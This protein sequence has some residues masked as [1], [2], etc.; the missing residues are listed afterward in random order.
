M[1]IERSLPTIHYSFTNLISIYSPKEDL[2]PNPWLC[3]GQIGSRDTVLVFKTS[4]LTVQN[5]DPEA[6]SSVTNID[7][8]SS[9]SKPSTILA[10]INKNINFQPSCRSNVEHSDDV[11]I[12]KNNEIISKKRSLIIDSMSSS[13]SDQ[14]IS[15]VNGD[16]TDIEDAILKLSD[17]YNSSSSSDASPQ[18]DDAKEIVSADDKEN[19]I[20]EI[21]D[22]SE[23]PGAVLQMTYRFVQTETRL[24]KKI[25]IA[26]GFTEASEDQHYNLLWTGVHIKADILRNLAPYQRVNHF[27]R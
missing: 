18:M 9:L 1:L 10:P 19:T 27:P 20:S 26:H 13:L 22:K 7:S 3:G 8:D 5:L 15:S 12:G 17:D 6:C 16:T 21:I 24:L 4:V 14:S 11:V 25:L 23:M 2:T